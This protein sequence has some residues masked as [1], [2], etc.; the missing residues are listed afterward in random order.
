VFASFIVFAPILVRVAK[1]FLKE[2]INEK[3]EEK[4]REPVNRIKF[5]ISL[6]EGYVSDTLLY[7]MPLWAFSS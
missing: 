5:N 3:E 7:P 1:F 2:L 6:A 4:R